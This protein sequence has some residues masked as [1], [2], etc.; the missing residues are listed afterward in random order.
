VLVAAADDQVG[1]ARRPD[2]AVV[3]LLEDR[4]HLGRQV[5]AVEVVDRVVELA[6]DPKRREA[7]KLDPYS[8]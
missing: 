2:P 8:T 4:E 7:E 1:R 5:L 6:G 3:E